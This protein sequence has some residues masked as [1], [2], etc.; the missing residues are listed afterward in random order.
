VLDCV[1][2]Y[3]DLVG[4]HLPH[5]T[6]L[7]VSQIPGE[8]GIQLIVINHSPW[9]FLLDA[10]KLSAVYEQQLIYFDLQNPDSIVYVA[11]W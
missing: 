11:Q 5:K 6:G 10:T 8:H 2:G 7:I 3:G 4:V 1:S 9:S